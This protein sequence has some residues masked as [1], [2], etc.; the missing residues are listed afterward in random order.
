[1][2]YL[3]PVRHKAVASR[4]IGGLCTEVTHVGTLHVRLRAV[5][6]PGGLP[7]RAFCGQDKRGMRRSC[8][9]VKGTSTMSCRSIVPRCYPQHFPI[10]KGPTSSAQRLRPIHLMCRAANLLWAPSGHSRTTHKRLV[11]CRR[12]LAQPAPPVLPRES[13][14]TMMQRL[15]GIDIARCPQCH[16]GRLVGIATLYPLHAPGQERETTHPP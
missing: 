13:A 16:Q 4:A 14:A 10:L 8:P 12:L 1:M 6:S 9:S 5:P 15:R 3:P 11:A 2:G 7:E